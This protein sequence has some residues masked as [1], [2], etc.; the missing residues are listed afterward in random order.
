MDKLGL[1]AS[2][3][4]LGGTALALGGTAL[5]RGMLA[6]GQVAKRQ[7]DLIERRQQDL[8]TP[9]YNPS[10]Y[11]KRA[12]AEF[13]DVKLAVFLPSM[14]GLTHPDFGAMF[15]PIRKGAASAAQAIPS[16]VG[17]GVG[18]AL[19]ALMTA[20]LSWAIQKGKKRFITDPGQDRAYDKAVMS[21]PQLQAAHRDAPEMLPTLFSTLRK[22][23]PSV[24]TDPLA[25]RTF[26][27]H[28]VATGGNLDFATLKL[29]A[30]TERLHKARLG[31]QP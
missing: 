24:A 14:S 27:T 12:Y 13:Q 23:A 15:D 26:L 19:G 29:L 5:F 2:T 8:S 18:A 6:S 1:K 21:D 25:V 16:S 20:P 10:V 17:K 7:Q 3:K 9:M 30:E 4:L 31:G 11:A 22:F 28:G